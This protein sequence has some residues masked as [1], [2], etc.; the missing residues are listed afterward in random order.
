MMRNILFAVLRRIAW[1]VLV[2]GGSSALAADDF[3]YTVRPGDHPWNIAQRFLK[4]PLL[5]PRLNRLNRIP[6]D[7]R[8]APGTV[9]RIP[10]EWLK[11]APSQVRLQTVHGDV[12]IASGL[13]PD[14]AAMPR[15][16]LE[17][18]AVVR[19]GLQSSATLEFQ[20]G[21]R[22]LVRQQSEIRLTSTQ[23]RVLDQGHQVE[24]ELLR[25]GMENLVQPN[26]RA[27]GRFE[28]RTPS[29]VAAV[30][31]TQFR[32]TATDTQTWTEVLEGAV[33]VGNAAG[34]TTTPAG[35]GSLTQSG[36][37]PGAAT[38]LLGAPD[39]STLP[40]VLERLPIDWPIPAIGGAVR[41]RTQIAPDPKFSA[42]LSDEVSGAPR[43]RVLDIP[44]G[45]HVVRV[46]AMDGSG[47][48]GV[49]AER[50]LVLRARPEPPLLIEPAP[51]A[52]T[53]AA[54]P[55]FR[56][57]QGH[58]SWHY[59]L[60]IT[61]TGESGEPLQHEQF[62]A[63]G[64]SATSSIELPAGLYRWRVA[65]I[66]PASGK[67]GPWGD[68]QG[69]RRVLPGPGVE[70]PLAAPGS[71]SLRWSAQPHTAS[72]RLQLSRDGSFN[73][74][75]LDAETT[76][77]QYA[78]KDLQAGTYHVRVLSVGKDGYAGPWGAAQTFVVPETP[79]PEHWRALLILLPGILL[80]L[81]L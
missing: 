20:D 79:A 76:E 74:P 63:A 36:K 18:G 71:V 37:A 10:A 67:Q 81:G 27:P 41:Y 59:R 46:R 22:V 75:L 72:H 42:L 51:D 6:N 78:L 62:I 29:A 5:G 31:G 35:T 52:V 9:L 14:R 12:R 11:L 7:R 56:W 2:A 25:G 43:V 66:D 65:S 13:G 54:Q 39:L 38:P 77:P 53:V 4:D 24:M 64:A 33:L 30:R 23:S 44:D 60:Q 28:I 47:L 50:A 1:C 8:I 55:T 26:A 40:A 32:V 68:A 17:A 45:E 48:E 69:F 61:R 49:S 15:E 57:T 16:L 19:T 80:L 73:T 58:P 34:Q 3:L 21:S 70:P